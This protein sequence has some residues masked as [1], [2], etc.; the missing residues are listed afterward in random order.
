[1]RQIST[2]NNHEFNN[3]SDYETTIEWFNSQISQLGRIFSI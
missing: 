3:I 2:C 1:M